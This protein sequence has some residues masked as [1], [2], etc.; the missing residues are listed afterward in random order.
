MPIGE[1]EWFEPCDAHE[2]HAG[3]NDYPFLWRF[4]ASH[5][6]TLFRI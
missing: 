6:P 3:H 4:Y 1:A 5:R 2:A